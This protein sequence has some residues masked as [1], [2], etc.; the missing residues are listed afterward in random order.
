MKKNLYV[1]KSILKVESI[2]EGRLEY[3]EKKV[4]YLENMIRNI[5]KTNSSFYNENDIVNIDENIQRSM[6][7]PYLRRMPAFNL[8]NDNHSVETAIL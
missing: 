5:H 1:D 7:I 8:T 3:L 4:L 2:I 6:S